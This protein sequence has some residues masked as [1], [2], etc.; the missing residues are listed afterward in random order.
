ME[1]KCRRKSNQH[2][3]SNELYLYVVKE[4]KKCKSIN[5]I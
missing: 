2:E 4:E 5:Q 1:H 3:H